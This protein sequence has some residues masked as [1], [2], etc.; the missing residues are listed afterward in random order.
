[1]NQPPT[2][3]LKNLTGVLPTYICHPEIFINFF[4]S[5]TY[6]AYSVLTYH[7]PAYPRKLFLS[8][9]DRCNRAPPPQGRKRGLYF[10][11]YS[12]APTG[13]PFIL[14]CQTRLPKR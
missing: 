3:T 1:M 14:P 10:P 5:S 6:S 7:L 2:S 13:C 4:T 9:R 12:L 8:C 11:P